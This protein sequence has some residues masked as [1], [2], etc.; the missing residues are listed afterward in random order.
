MYEY[1]TAED[2]WRVRA[3]YHTRRWFAQHRCSGACV[4]VTSLALVTAV[5]AASALFFAGLFGARDAFVIEHSEH[6]AYAPSDARGY[7]WWLTELDQPTLDASAASSEAYA[8]QRENVSGVVAEHVVRAREAIVESRFMVLLPDT[9]CDAA[10]LPPMQCA[11]FSALPSALATPRQKEILRMQYAAT[12]FLTSSRASCVCGPELGYP[13]RYVGVRMLLDGLP[14]TLADGSVLHMF[15][16]VDLY[17]DLYATLDASAMKRRFIGL[18]VDEASQDYR[19]NASR[20]TFKLVLPTQVH[21]EYENRECR[22]ALLTNTEREHV[23]RGYC[24]RQCLDM[25]DGVDVRERARRQAALGVV[26]NKAYF[27]NESDDRPS[28]EFGRASANSR[29]HDEL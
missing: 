7:I 4:L 6:F 26:L 14:T 20:G 5:F 10:A 21:V 29:V 19:Y 25:L 2:G 15:N 16:P 13:Y 3:A 1:V 9:V 27:A 22:A 12:R 18:A 8:V 24:I 17:A 28:C 23:Q 11:D